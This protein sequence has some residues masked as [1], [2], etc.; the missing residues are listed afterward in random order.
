MN[1]LLKKIEEY[2]TLVMFKHTIFSLSFGLVS[3]LLATGGALLGIWEFALIL[4]ALLAARTGANAIN[5][6]IDA[7]IDAA[8][9]RTATRQIPMGSMRKSEALL[10]AAACF[11]VMVVSAWLINPLCGMLSPLALLMMLAYSY[12][13][14]FTWLCHIILGITCGLAPLGAWLAVTGNFGGLTAVFAALSSFDFSGAAA[15]LLYALRYDNAIF[16]PIALFIANATWVAGF[17]TIYGTQDFDHDRANGIFSI[18]AR[19]GIKR[20]LWIS[21]GLHVVAVVALVVAGILAPILGGL[22]FAAITIV[23]VLLMYEHAIV[24][25][26]NLTRATIASYNVNEIIGIVFMVFSLVDILVL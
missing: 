14:R 13:K 18:P 21:S 16:V 4:I 8:N 26:D 5:R 10:F 25:P 1:K 24:K 6:V 9:P 3:L 20:A 17:D 11:V 2:G 19:F 7:E 15:Y 12:T 23:G 22:Y